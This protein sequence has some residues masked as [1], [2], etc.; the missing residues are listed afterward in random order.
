MGWLREYNRERCTAADYQRY[1]QHR[2]RLSEESAPPRASS[3]PI[4]RLPPAPA[5]RPATPEARQLLDLSDALMAERN[6]RKHDKERDSLEHSRTPPP[7][8]GRRQDAIR[9]LTRT[10]N[11]YQT[12]PTLRPY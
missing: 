7:R 9:L 5:R 2:A 1:N 6:K 11:E 3:T 8:P 4:P 12:M 10:P